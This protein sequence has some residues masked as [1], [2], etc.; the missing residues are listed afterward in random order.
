MVAKIN[1][2]SYIEQRNSC[3]CGS[4]DPY[5]H[6]CL[7]DS[8][9]AIVKDAKSNSFTLPSMSTGKVTFNEREMWADLVFA[10]GPKYGRDR[11]GDLLDITGIDTRFHRRNPFSLVDH[12]RWHPRPIAKCMTPAGEYTVTLDAARDLAIA[13]TYFWQRPENFPKDQEWLP[14]TIFDGIVKGVYNAGSISARPV[15]ATLLPE[16]PRSGL[17]SGVHFHKVELVEPTWC[18]FPVNASSIRDYLEKGIACGRPIPSLIRKSLEPYAEPKKAWLGVPHNFGKPALSLVKKC[19][20]E[21][22]MAPSSATDDSG[23]IQRPPVQ[24]SAQAGAAK[25]DPV[26]GVRQDE[27]A[28]EKYG[29]QLSRAIFGDLLDMLEHYTDLLGPLEDNEMISKFQTLLD[30]WHDQA[31]GVAADFGSK[32]P[33]YAPIEDMHRLQGRQKF[34]SQVDKEIP[35]AQQTGDQQK[36][37]LAPPAQFNE[38]KKPGEGKPM[39]EKPTDERHPTD[40]T[41]PPGK[42]G[43]EKEGGKAPPPRQP[44]ESKKDEK[45]K[46]MTETSKAMTDEEVWALV[47]SKLDATGNKIKDIKERQEKI[48]AERERLA[49]CF[50]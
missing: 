21:K 50:A 41:P 31:T 28:H 19:F 1:V 36:T 29:A 25:A 9:V 45:N 18:V 2:W 11:K 33:G 4:G 13:R 35:E 10:A 46:A 23:A 40:Q 7:L 49:K 16:D 17:P 12:G 39:E 27:T 37:D 32:Y 44:E 26:M 6:R 8:Q 20:V 34:G 38:E 3:R 47:M 42:K 43:D 5:C 14:E 22:Q 15:Y 30:N 24:P 48:D